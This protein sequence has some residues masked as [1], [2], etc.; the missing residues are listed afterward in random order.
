MKRFLN[1]RAQRRKPGALRSL[2]VYLKD[3]EV[4]F[5]G[6]G[7]PNGSLFPFEG[8][9]VQIKNGETLKLDPKI[10][11]EGALQYSPSYGVPELVQEIKSLQTKQHS[12]QYS[13]WDTLMTCGSQAGLRKAF[14]NFLEEGDYV[15]VE[16]PTY[17]TA[18][19]MLNVLDVKPI[20]INMD[21]NGPFPEH[22]RSILENWEKDHPNEKRPKVFYTIP[23]GQNPSGVSALEER[24]EKIYQI[25]KEYDLLIMEDDPYWFL[26]FDD[27]PIK[28]YLS[29]DT[30]GRVLR[31]DSFSKVFSA[32][33]RLG[34]ATGH[35]DLIEI[36]MFDQQQDCMHPS[37]FTQTIVY[38]YL[39]QIGYD[40]LLSHVQNVKSFYE[41]QRNMFV[42]I[43]EKHLSDLA[44][45]SIPH[46][47]MFFWIKV[48]NIEDTQELIKNTVEEK[49]ILVPGKL[50]TV[51]HENSSCLRASYS[52]IS[53]EK[54]DIALSRL[55]NA[56]L[57]YL[58]K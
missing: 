49:V 34:W 38:C 24:K 27:Q 35:K 33:I 30:D 40:G 16:N 58:N 1:K 28:S 45:W 10:L 5:L 41:S 55:R 51:G 18:L 47:G 43:A 31:F 48:N 12:I 29:L 8:V 44:S 21:N 32:G 39:K 2:A 14:D 25:A 6:A 19:E 37:G 46:A 50:F 7:L 42:R 3:P 9:Q 20:P 17:S 11:Y 52:N 13:D 22:L 36:M 15:L 57:K 53:E 56:I 26:K 4:I 54:L 23:I